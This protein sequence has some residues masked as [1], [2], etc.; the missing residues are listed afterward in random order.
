M[1]VAHDSLP[2]VI[3]FVDNALHLKTLSHEHSRVN[4]C[5]AADASWLLSEDERIKGTWK[6]LVEWVDYLS[7][8]LDARIHSE[9]AACHH[10]SS[11]VCTGCVVAAQQQGLHSL[12]AQMLMV[13]HHGVQVL[14]DCRY[15]WHAACSPEEF[16]NRVPELCLYAANHSCWRTFVP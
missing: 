14:R 11:N 2:R 6:A 9:Y 12:I 8:H 16:A 1:Q 10:C 3:L 5:S 7:Y 13:Q 4:N 15:C